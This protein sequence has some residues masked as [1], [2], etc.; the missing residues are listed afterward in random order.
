MSPRKLAV[1]E[2]SYPTTP[3]ASIPTYKIKVS[4]LTICIPINTENLKDRCKKLETNSEKLKK[5]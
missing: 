4:D 3:L 1:V 5:F 2:K